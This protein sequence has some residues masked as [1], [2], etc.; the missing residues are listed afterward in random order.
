MT[1][2]EPTKKP[3]S[4][5]WHPA[6]VVAALRKSGWSLRKLSE[7]YNYKA[8]TTLQKALYQ[9]YPLAERRIAAAIGVAPATIWPSRYAKSTKKRGPHGG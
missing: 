6:D 7:H 9:S 2:N 3:A 5:D 4:E 8:H 1:P